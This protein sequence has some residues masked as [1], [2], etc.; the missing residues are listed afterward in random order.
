[1]IKMNRPINFGA[2]PAAL[3]NSVLQRIQEDL[4]NWENTGISILETGHR[5]APFLDLRDKLEASVRRI[6]QVPEDFSILFLLGGG[7][8]Q[9]AVATMNL[10]RG[11]KKANYVLTG[12]WSLTAMNEARKYIDVHVAASSQD[13]QFTTIPEVSTWDILPEAALLHFTDNETIGGLEFPFVPELGSMPLV[14]DMSSNI[15]SRPIDFTNIGCIYACAQKNM[16]IAGMSLV[17]VHRDLL[18][19][20]LPETPSVFHYA[21]QVK[22]RSLLSTP[23]TFAWYVAS[24][25]LNW[26]EEEGGLALLSERNLEKACLLYNYIDSSEFYRNAIDPRFRSRM[27]IPFTLVNSRLESKFFESAKHNGLLNLQ[28]HRTLG[29]AR[30]SIYNSI[31]VGDVKKLID[32]MM[33]FADKYI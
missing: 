5:S 29:G 10:V 4:F 6:L 25:M 2:G 9:F 15:F 11:F 21:S 24:L 22:N 17:M 12:H 30:A 33:Y 31:G 19:R 18:D 3:P 28:G 16:G 23:A 20:A 7:Q 8:T 1:M 26:L 13:Q 27:N 14:S 32:F